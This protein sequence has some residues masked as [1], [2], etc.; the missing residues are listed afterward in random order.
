[1]PYCAVPYRVVPYCV[2][3]SSAGGRLLEST[4][5]PGAGSVLLGARTLQEGGAFPGADREAVELFCI[6]HQVMVE[7]VAAEEALVLDFQGVATLGP[8]AGSEGN[9]GG[10]HAGTTPISGIE[11]IMQVAHI[12]LTDFTYEADAFQ[13]AQQHAH[14]LQDGVTKSLETACTEAIISKVTGHDTR[15]VCLFV[16]LFVFSSAQVF[17]DR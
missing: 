12:I 16:C 13:R 2:V 5:I 4:R 7:V 14:E 3:S 15:Y 17:R 11:A 1:V 10:S 6:D 9:L 8:G